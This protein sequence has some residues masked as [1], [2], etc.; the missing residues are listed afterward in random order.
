[1]VALG[2]RM[3]FY[4]ASFYLGRALGPAGIL[5]IEARAASFGRFV[6]W[7]ERLFA[8][9]SHAVV[10]V[11]AGPTVGALAGI[12]GMRVGTFLALATTGL[13]VR[14]VLVIWFA[15]WLRE[16]LEELLALIDEYWVPGTVVLASSVAL[17][18][19]RRLRAARR[20]RSA[21]PRDA[22]PG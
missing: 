7:L 5:W 4:L 8:R 9:A 2:R 18:Q 12:S 19:W 17:I 16:P 20:Q 14:L 13:F 10:L 6:R 15:E 21:E 22:S 1:M 11:M 3:L